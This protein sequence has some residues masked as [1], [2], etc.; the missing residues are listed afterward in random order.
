MGLFDFF[1]IDEIKK[2]SAIL[3]RN[4]RFFNHT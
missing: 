3:K 4:C 1:K 2:D